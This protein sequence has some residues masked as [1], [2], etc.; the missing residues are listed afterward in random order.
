MKSMIFRSRHIQSSYSISVYTRERGGGARR[1]EQFIFLAAMRKNSE[2]VPGAF[3]YDGDYFP[4]RM[5]YERG[6]R[7][8]DVA[9]K[10]HK[11]SNRK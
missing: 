5:F 10:H 9:G 2:R 8:K 3:C 7:E 11:A 6:A 1:S 4:R